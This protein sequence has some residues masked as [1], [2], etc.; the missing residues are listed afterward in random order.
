MVMA[1]LRALRR[2]LI[3]RD[4]R[5][6]RERRAPRLWERWRPIA[7]PLILFATVGLCF[8]A[9]QY[10][11]DSRN[12]PY[13]ASVIIGFF[14]VLPVLLA[15]YRPLT[16]WR[17]GFIGLFVGVINAN[18]TESWPWNP[19]QI[20]AFLL[21]LG[22][23]ALFAG[24]GVV[25]WAAL[26]T[27][28]PVFLYVEQANAYGVAALFLAVLVVGDQIRR[29]RHH[30]AGPARAGRG[31]RAGKG[32]ARGARG[33]HPDRPGDARRG[34]APHVDDRGA[35]GDRPVPADRP[36]AAGPGR[37]RR[38]SPAPPAPRSPTCGGCSAC[39]AAR[40]TARR[41]APQPGIADVPELV[42]AAQRVGVAV[43]LAIDP[44]VSTVDGPVG[45]AAYRIVQEA[46]A[47]AARHA[48]GAPVTVSVTQAHGAIHVRVVNEA[49]PLPA[50]GPSGVVSAGLGLA[51]MR[52][53][54]ALLGGTLD[55]GPTDDG[56]FAVAATLPRTDREDLT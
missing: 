37:V 39:C 5:P 26:I 20:F 3:G 1:T 50:P 34:R 18:P 15:Y 48:P 28:I 17:L 23:L 6:P 9:A 30:P 21:I 33:A 43:A 4:Y 32:P 36:A 42:T 46:L 13:S 31:Q 40:P 45:L 35:G 51:G 54:A 41:T 24:T 2:L 53:R 8:A 44:E 29:R 55:A 56:G 14:T 16:A 11:E 19:V 47:N 49:A 22:A 12:L 27:L 7:I 10:L 52:E 25:A 38:R